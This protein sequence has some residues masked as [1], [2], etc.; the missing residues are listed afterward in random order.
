MALPKDEFQDIQGIIRSG[1][2]RLG[3]ACFLLLEITEAAEA[4]AW[5]RAAAGDA[6]PETGSL[7]YRVTHAGELGTGQHQEQALQLAFT[8]QG[9]RKLGLPAY[10]FQAYPN[11]DSF[12]REFYLGMTGEEAREEGR[13]RRLGDVEANDPSYWEWGAPGF[14]PDVLVMLYAD[15]ASSLAAFQRIV[16]ADTALGFEVMQILGSPGSAEH[17]G[18]LRREP[19]G[20]I[21]G[22][23]QPAVDWAES[24]TPGTGADLEYGNLIAPG[25]FILGYKNEY[26]FYTERPLLDPHDDPLN[27][28]PEA[29]D[30]PG[31]RDLGRNGTY[32]VFR[33]LDQDVGG[34]WRFAARRSRV[35][36]G[37]SLAEA[38]VGRRLANGD[39]LVPPS[40]I[41][42]RGVGPEA[43][44]LR[45]NGFTFDSDPDGFACPFGAHI[46]RANPRTGDL[47]GGRQGLVSKLL[48]TLGLK[49]GRPR[50]DTVSSSRFHRIIRRGRPY[51]MAADRESILKEEDHGVKSG[52]YFIALNANIARQFEFIQNAW[53]MNTIFNGLQGESDP[54]VGNRVP[55]PFGR[56]SD[57]FTWPQ[58]SG[59]ACKISGLPQFVTVRG[60]AYFFLPGIRALRFIAGQEAKG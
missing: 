58:P 20:F 26:G 30:K 15:S 9:L 60:G 1:Y 21:D 28:L 24:R 10:L 14:I 54:L 49:R 34:F 29:E 36:N 44:D 11:N 50:E 51:G 17:D 48:R 27:L 19:F 43:S 52:I 8:A 47:P 41:S 45:Q 57:G 40:S 55:W 7:S 35:D 33:Q 38:M 39:P 25:E 42:I 18:K 46:R 32:L 5:L 53:I 6:A 37:V 2:G 12:S 23:S 13:L 4:K 31:K 22:I 59:R 16:V 3:E 56:P